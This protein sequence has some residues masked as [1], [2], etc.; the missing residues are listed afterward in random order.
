MAKRTYK[1]KEQTR[2]IHTSCF[3]KLPKSYNKQDSVIQPKD[4]HTES[5]EMN[6]HIHGQFIINKAIQSFKGQKKK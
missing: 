3:N 2:N 5:P 4:R 1:K 6:P